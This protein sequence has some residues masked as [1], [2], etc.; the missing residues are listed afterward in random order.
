MR[1][2]SDNVLTSDSS[3]RV[4]GAVTHIY[5][6]EHTSAS[7]TVHIVYSIMESTGISPLLLAALGFLGTVYV[8]SAATA[9]PFLIVDIGR[10]LDS[11]KTI[12]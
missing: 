6:E 7:N 9:K 3:V 2:R 11:R 10:N 8:P 1:E 12:C 5:A 4:I